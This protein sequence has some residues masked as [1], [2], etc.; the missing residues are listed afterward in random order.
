M[1][2]PKSHR[3]QDILAKCSSCCFSAY[4]EMS[5]RLFCVKD[6]TV[7]KSGCGEIVTLNGADMLGMRTAEFSKLFNTHLVLENDVCDEYKAR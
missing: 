4:P 5:S 7:V 6:D 1:T 2:R 3:K